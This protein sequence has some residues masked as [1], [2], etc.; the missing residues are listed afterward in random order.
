MRWQVFRGAS[1][2]GHVGRTVDCDATRFIHS[3]VRRL[4]ETLRDSPPR[5]CLVIASS[6]IENLRDASQTENGR[7]ALTDGRPD[8][9]RG[10]TRRPALYYRRPAL[11]CGGHSMELGGSPCTHGNSSHACRLVARLPGL[12]PINGMP[13]KT[14]AVCASRAARLDFYRTFTGRPFC[15]T[16]SRTWPR[17]A[18]LETRSASCSRPERTRPERFAVV[19]PPAPASCSQVKDGLSYACRYACR[20]STSP[21]L[22]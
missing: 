11:Y 6:P 1:P 3:W 10:G 20:R 17:A 8:S 4:I 13:V 18:R 16:P 19:D 15:S 22:L 12:G 5:N 2:H 9:L 21:C 14:R 7:L